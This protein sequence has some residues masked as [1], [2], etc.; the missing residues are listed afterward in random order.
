M[1]RYIEERAV[2]IANY[3]VENNAT[4]YNY[5]YISINIFKITIKYY[6]VFLRKEMKNKIR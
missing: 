5:G 1:K 6:M 4:N 2:E 3:I